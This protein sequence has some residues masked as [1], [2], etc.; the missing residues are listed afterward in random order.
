MGWVPTDIESYLLS[1]VAIL[2]P[3]WRAGRRLTASM[4]PAGFGKHMCG[5]ASPG[6]AHLSFTVLGCPLTVTP[7][8]RFSLRRHRLHPSLMTIAG[9]GDGPRPPA[10]II[11]NE[12]LPSP[13]LW[14][15]S[16]RLSDP[17]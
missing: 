1:R 14:V 12:D 11:T 17:A 9:N 2:T 10:V 6:L 5:T 15:L 16:L 13:R 3:S 8:P 7:R 4:L